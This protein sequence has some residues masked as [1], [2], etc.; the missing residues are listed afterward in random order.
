MPPRW[1]YDSQDLHSVITRHLEKHRSLIELPAEPLY[2]SYGFGKAGAVALDRH[3][4]AHVAELRAVIVDPVPPDRAFLGCPWKGRHR[5]AINRCKTAGGTSVPS[6]RVV[7]M[8]V[9]NFIA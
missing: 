4:D 5:E 8:S 1:S 2:G 3:L 9:V 6:F 7:G